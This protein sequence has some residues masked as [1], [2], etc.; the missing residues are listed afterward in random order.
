MHPL[1]DAAIAEA[2]TTLNGWSHADG[3]I[4]KTYTLPNYPAGLMFASAVG[5][6]CEAL[7]HHPDMTIGYKKVTVRFTTHDAGSAVT[8]KDLAAARAI[9]ALGYPKS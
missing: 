5:A 9:E 2:L 7:D 6:L 8:D 3:A 1:D 4:S